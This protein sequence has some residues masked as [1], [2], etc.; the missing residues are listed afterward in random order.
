MIVV[1]FLAISLTN[2]GVQL[3][4]EHDAVVLRTIITFQGS[5]ADTL[6]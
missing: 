5:M 4:N 3:H 2:C 6:R 1:F